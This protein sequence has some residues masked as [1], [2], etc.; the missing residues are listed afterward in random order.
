MSLSFSVLKSKS[1]Q[2]TKVNQMGSLFLPPKRRTFSEL[3][4]IT[5]QKFAL[6]IVTA[7]KT[8]INVKFIDFK[9]EK[10]EEAVV[11]A[12]RKL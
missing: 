4:R 12:H 3:C 7:V 9:N 6:F 11:Y 2:E 10:T 5:T 8:Q 1:K